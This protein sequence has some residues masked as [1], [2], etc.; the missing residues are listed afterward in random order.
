MY[1]FDFSKFRQNLVI[2]WADYGVRMN[3]GNYNWQ[4]VIWG[5]EALYSGLKLEANLLPS[6]FQ[7]NVIADD[8][9]KLI[10]VEVV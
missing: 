1:E 10:Y 7:F 5:L 6:N 3:F 8:L 2:K 4:D 9:F